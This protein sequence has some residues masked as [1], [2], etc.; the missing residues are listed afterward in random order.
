MT[1]YALNIEN[2]R[3]NYGKLEAVKSVSFNIEKGEIF[4]LLGPNGAGKSTIIN[5]ITGIGIRD[6]GVVDVF[7]KD[8]TK[9]YMFT[10]K[11]IGVVPQETISDGY[12][13]VEE[14]LQY[15]SGFY[16]I[17]NNSKRIEDV[18]KKLQLFSHK[19]KKVEQ[20][21]GG[22]KR[23]L[24]IAKALVHEPSLFILDEPTAGVDVQLRHKLWQYVREINQKGTT[25]LLT[26]HYIEEAENLCNRIG[27]LNHGQLIEINNVQGF[28]NKYGNKTLEEIFVELTS[29]EIKENKNAS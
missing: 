7:G 17:K 29:R 19:Q 9:E 25:I 21:S 4:G 3:K 6:S 13:S 18:L 12:F 16:G 20:L 24:L 8:V 23:R 10:R 22:M 1:E 26:T 28:K 27:I 5:I 14:I 11:K 2:L 15:Q